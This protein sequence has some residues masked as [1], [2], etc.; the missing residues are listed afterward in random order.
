M[1]LNA[2]IC[3]KLPSDELYSSCL[4]GHDQND[5]A[6]N[7]ELL[8]ALYATAWAA[9]ES[10]HARALPLSVILNKSRIYLQLVQISLLSNN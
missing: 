3:F 1:C 7:A 4:I 9:D 10:S 5:M 8:V 2:G 6:V